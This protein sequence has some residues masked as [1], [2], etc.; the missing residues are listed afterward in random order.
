ML[1]GIIVQVQLDA[2][3]H[4]TRFH[5]IHVKQKVLNTPKFFAAALEME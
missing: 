4:D 2:A 3:M 1:Y 5:E